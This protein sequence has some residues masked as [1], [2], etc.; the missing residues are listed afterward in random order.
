[1]MLSDDGSIAKNG[2]LHGFDGSSMQTLIAQSLMGITLSF[3]FKFL[4]NI[5]YVISL[6]VSMLLTAIFSIIFYDFECSVL[7]VCSL[8]I[9]VLSIYLFY[10]QKI[11]ERFN[12]KENEFIF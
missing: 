11:I 3:L 6:T 8:V 12:W 10:R 7:F 1:M 2:I 5:V 9:V 4:D